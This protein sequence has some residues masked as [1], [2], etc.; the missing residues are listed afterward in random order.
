[1]MFLLHTV[2]WWWFPDQASEV[3]VSIVILLSRGEKAR[4]LVV[5]CIA[6]C[7][8]SSLYI[9]VPIAKYPKI[10]FRE[11]CLPRSPIRVH[12]MSLQ[13][14][15]HFGRAEIYLSG[16]VLMRADAFVDE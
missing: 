11:L 14:S 6:H 15:R 8:S 4:L 13:N 9:N 2:V 5:W 16:G 7:C 12:L 3:G 1:M 10:P